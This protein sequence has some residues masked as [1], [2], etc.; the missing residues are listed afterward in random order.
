M[1]IVVPAWWDPKNRKL[2][3]DADTIVCG[4]LVA[5]DAEV[6]FASPDG[7]EFGL[8]ADQLGVTWVKW[9]SACRLRAAAADHLVYLM[10]PVDGAPR[11]SRGGLDRIA[12]SLTQARDLGDLVD[13]VADL[14][15]LADIT[16]I[17]GV[18][19][20]SVKAVSSVVALRRARRNR[21]TLQHHFE[22]HRTNL[23]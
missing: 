7:I 21:Q 10:P 9:G 4:V 2:I 8:A 20:D 16:G 15:D 14:G 11:L 18:L 22:T 12:E 23:P 5:D 1:T 17:A 19:G 3:L 6:C 13:A